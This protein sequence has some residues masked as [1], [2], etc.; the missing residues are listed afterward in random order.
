[1]RAVAHSPSFAKKVGIPQSVGQKF[2]THKAEGGTVKKESPAMVK[3]EMAFMKANKAPASM[4]KHEKAEA[5]GKGYARGGG[6]ESKALDALASG[7]EKGSFDEDVYERARKFVNRGGQDEAPKPRPNPAAKAAPAPS[8]TPAPKASSADIPKGSESAPASTGKSTSG[9]SD[10]DRV[11]MGL[12]VGAGAA[13]VGRGI[14]SAYGKLSKARKA[15]AEAAEVA[16]RPRPVSPAK[17]TEDFT[18]GLSRATQKAKEE[19]AVE[20]ARKATTKSQK[21]SPRASSRYKEDE[22]GVEF[23]RGGS[24]RGGGCEQRGKTR[25][26]FV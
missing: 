18:A 15:A 2:E 8:P 16:K 22:A 5:K 19:P 21:A 9:P 12:G 10:V 24:V 14:M 25:G 6:I 17:M 11:L 26:R 1:M 7:E 13:G 3:K 23:K 4:M 20:A